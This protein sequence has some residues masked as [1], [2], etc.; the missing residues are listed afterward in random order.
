MV[1]HVGLLLPLPLPRIHAFH[2]AE[3]V[4]SVLSSED[5]KPEGQRV[6]R[7]RRGTHKDPI[8]DD[9]SR[10]SAARSAEAASSHPQLLLDVKA[11]DE[12][13]ILV[14]VEPSQHEDVPVEGYRLSTRRP[15]SLHRHKDNK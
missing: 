8:A 10:E 14:A 5:L 1:E 4:K 9:T 13:E 11:I 3:S 6:G 12:I 15:M 7:E 2:S